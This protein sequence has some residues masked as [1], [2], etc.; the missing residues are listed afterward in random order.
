[1]AKL[2]DIAKVCGVDNSTVS[3]ALKNDAR[4]SEATTLKV[5][6]AAQKLGYQP[7]LA[8]RML[9]QGSSKIFWVLV[10]ALGTI[11]DWRIAERA[12][13]TAA[14]K[15]YDTA[16]AV[17]HGSQEDFE[18]LITT[19]SSGLAAGVIINR[20]DIRDISS[21]K[22]LIARGFPVVFVDVPVL[23][24]DL[25]VVTTDHRLATMQL[26]EEVVR[27]GA[28][29]LLFLSSRSRNRVEER[30]YEGAVHAMAR[31]GLRGLFVADDPDWQDHLD[32]DGPLAVISSGQSFVEEFMREHGD[33]L[34]RRPLI[35]GCF[36]EWRGALQPFEKG[37]VVEQDYERL[38]DAALEHLFAMINAEALPPK[39]E[40]PPVRLRIIE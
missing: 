14:E 19:I 25:G 11:V 10:P 7:N 35:L 37:A 23:S 13:L 12:S 36:D 39:K 32:P 26:V 15:G 34:A 22:A 33:L 1:M 8:A 17:H 30:R 21:V 3:R 31:A 20:R 29:Q 16:I 4:I 18:R 38:A 24:L 40:F 5:Q 27:Q 28:K 6:A 2:A 9:K